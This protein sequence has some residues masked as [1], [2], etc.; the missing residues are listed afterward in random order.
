[1]LVR[2]SG[3]VDKGA[4]PHYNR[5][6]VTDCGFSGGEKVSVK[7]AAGAAQDKAAAQEHAVYAVVEQGGKQYRVSRGDLV[8]FERMPGEEGSK[9]ELSRVL[10]VAEKDRVHIGRPTVKRASVVGE[11][12]KQTRGKKVVSLKYKRRKDQRKKIGHRQELSQV[13]IMEIRIPDA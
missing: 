4:R 1:M 10:L 7:K 12:V 9:V 8:L 2:V 3:V 13:R 11:M 6:I 5:T